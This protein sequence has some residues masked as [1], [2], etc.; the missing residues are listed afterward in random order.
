MLCLT[1]E[2]EDV[3]GMSML[4]QLNGIVNVVPCLALNECLKC[5]LFL[6]V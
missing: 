1:D 2:N 4:Q 3:N 5:T 6:K